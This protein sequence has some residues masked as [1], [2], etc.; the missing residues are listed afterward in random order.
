MF[1]SYY[2]PYFP[3]IVI[4]ISLLFAAMF[5]F[6][7]TCQLYLFFC[8]ECIRLEIIAGFWWIQQN[9]YITMT[10]VHQSDKE[11]YLTMKC[12]SYALNRCIIYI[13]GI[14]MHSSGRK[15]IDDLLPLPLLHFSHDVFCS[16]QKATSIQ[17]SSLCVLKCSKMISR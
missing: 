9:Q 2:Q 17:Y 5:L 11:F 1:P 14:S 10:L 7:M 6:C 15:Y 16:L 12:S 3:P 13:Y 8:R 4:H